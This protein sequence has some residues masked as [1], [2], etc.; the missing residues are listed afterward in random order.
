MSDIR[1]P[2]IDSDKTSNTSVTPD[3]FFALLTRFIVGEEAQEIFLSIFVVNSPR[4]PILWNSTTFCWIDI[5]VQGSYGL[6][7]VLSV[8]MHSGQ[9]D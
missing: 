9:R 7:A 4:Q 8:T 3:S 1:P 5:P 2:W 6:V